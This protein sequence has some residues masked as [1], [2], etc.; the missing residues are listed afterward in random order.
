MSTITDDITIEQFWQRAEV[1][2][3]SYG[4]RIWRARAIIAP[5]EHNLTVEGATAPGPE[6]AFSS[7]VDFVVNEIVT[8]NLR[9]DPPKRDGQIEWY[10]KSLRAMRT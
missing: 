1:R 2:F 9:H 7:L 6:S 3:T 8:G 10:M 5:Q 4:S